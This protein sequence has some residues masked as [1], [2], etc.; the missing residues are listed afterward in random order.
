MDLDFDNP[1]ARPGYK[2]GSDLKH[3]DLGFDYIIKHGL[4][5]WFLDPKKISQLLDHVKVNGTQCI[6]SIT[7]KFQ[8]QD[9]FL[10]KTKVEVRKIA[11]F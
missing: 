1:Q 7:F 9:F 10:W 11:F 2:F 5:E 4:R 3:V 8:T 6:W